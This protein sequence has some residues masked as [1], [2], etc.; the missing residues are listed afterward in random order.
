MWGERS[1][2]CGSFVLPTDPVL[3]LRTPESFVGFRTPCAVSIQADCSIQPFPTGILSPPQTHGSY[4]GNYLRTLFLP[5]SSSASQH[6]SSIHVNW[7]PLESWNSSTWDL[8]HPLNKDIGLAL[9]CLFQAK[10]P[11]NIPCLTESPSPYHDYSNF[12]YFHLKCCARNHH[13]SLTVLNEQTIERNLP[14]WT[15]HYIA[16]LSYSKKVADKF[17]AP[18]SNNSIG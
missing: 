7:R 16:L 8:S 1:P 15:G 9:Q 10:L 12:P 5:M 17:W 6:H 13:D 4:F 3:Y 14:C 11:A 2:C 18:E